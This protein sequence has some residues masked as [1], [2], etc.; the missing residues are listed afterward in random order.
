MASFLDLSASVSVWMPRLRPLLGREGVRAR[1]LPS[2][3]TAEEAGEAGHS[4]EGA[5]VSDVV[6][7]RSIAARKPLPAMTL[8]WTRVGVDSGPGE[9]S[10]DGLLGRAPLP[11]S[12]VHR[13]WR[14]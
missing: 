8:L 12:P 3:E 14:F 13:D 1:L 7:T 6:R 4:A 11:D 10:R 2:P 9:E 5:P